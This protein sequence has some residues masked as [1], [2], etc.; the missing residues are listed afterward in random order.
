M[1]DE[2]IELFRDPKAQKLKGQGL[3]NQQKN[4]DQDGF[5]SVMVFF[6]RTGQQYGN[7]Y[8]KAKG[9][10]ILQKAKNYSHDAPPET[11]GHGRSD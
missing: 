4:T 3:S 10:C 11:A 2:G 5:G 6:L 8:T 9:H 7:Q 1:D